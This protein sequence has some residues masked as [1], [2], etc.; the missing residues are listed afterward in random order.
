MPAI[1]E[2]IIG[3]A[4]IYLTLSL[5]C[6]AI[7]ELVE[8]G[9][10]KR[11]KY[12]R[13][14]I[15]EILGSDLA[16]KVYDHP[17]ITVLGSSAGWVGRPE[18]HDPAYIPARD[19]A[20]ALVAAVAAPEGDNRTQVRSPKDKLTQVTAR[21][22]NSSKDIPCGVRSLIADQLDGVKGN[23]AE[24][25]EQLQKKLEDLF[26]DAMDRLSGFYKRQAKKLVLVWAIAVALG[27]N[28]DTFAFARTLWTDETVRAAVVAKAEAV[29]AEESLPCV[30]PSPGSSP[31]PTPSPSPPTSAG[32]TE[33]LE[34]EVKAVQDI[35]GLGIPLGWPD[36]PWNLSQPGVKD[37][38]RTPLSCGDW[39]LKLLGIAVTVLALVQ[40]APFWFDTL[41]KLVDIRATGRRPSDASG[42][43]V[44]QPGS[45]S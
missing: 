44:T 30:E 21:V 10:K 5:V 34:C 38:P 31:S 15:T 28:A 17:L 26:N 43:S 20:Q 4:L 23:D 35:R 2:V 45:G 33:T 41:N 25:L 18:R 37:D 36:W 22:T 1:L 16:T 13:N 42:G 27:L 11:S 12:L 32:L 29:A 6:S 7:Q 3:L 24:K 8:A 14:K 40:G 19:F 9:F 39:I